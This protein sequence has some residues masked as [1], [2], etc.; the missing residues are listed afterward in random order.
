MHT[1]LYE[2]LFWDD[3]DD[4]YYLVLFSALGIL[5]S[6]DFSGDSI[7]LFPP[8]CPFANDEASFFVGV[9]G[10]STRTF[11]CST[12]SFEDFRLCISVELAE[13]KTRVGRKCVFEP[14]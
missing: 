8:L 2:A 4:G 3:R 12:L 13:R 7:F 6:I 10:W 11:S 9:L 14:M 1:T 5:F